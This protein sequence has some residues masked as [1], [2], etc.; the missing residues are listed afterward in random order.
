[1]ENCGESEELGHQHV[2]ESSSPSVSLRG[3]E[4]PQNRRKPGDPRGEGTCVHFRKSLAC[5]PKRASAVSKPSHFTEFSPTQGHTVKR[6][7][8]YL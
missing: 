4:F 7:D 2:P 5:S 6:R 8:P 1:M 3:G